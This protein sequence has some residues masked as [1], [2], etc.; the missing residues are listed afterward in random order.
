MGLI[1][2][3]VAGAVGGVGDKRGVWLSG[4]VINLSPQKLG[5]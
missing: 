4:S 3:M 2:G 5:L 1:D